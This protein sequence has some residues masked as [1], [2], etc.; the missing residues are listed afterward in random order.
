[1]AHQCSI[2]AF[3]YLHF[4]E[5]LL[6]ACSSAFAFFGFWADAMGSVSNFRHALFH[7]PRRALAFLLLAS[8]TL[9]SLLWNWIVTSHAVGRALSILVCLPFVAGAFYVTAVP[10]AQR[11]L[12]PKDQDRVTSRF[13]EIR[14]T[15]PLIALGM[16]SE[17]SL[18]CMP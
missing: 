6:A 13:R 5:E 3:L 14:N 1:M 9:L 18:S 2:G 10:P 11:H 16:S 15:V 7:N 8:A 4:S 12:S 17:M